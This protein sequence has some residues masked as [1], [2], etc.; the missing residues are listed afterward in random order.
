M[1]YV[2]SVQTS[3]ERKQKYHNVENYGATPT[4]A[5]IYRDWTQGH[6]ERIAIPFL[7]L[8]KK[9]NKLKQQ[10]KE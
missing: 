5:R 3:E 9:R 10:P 4:Q 7:K 8:Q 2:N 1:R 6:I